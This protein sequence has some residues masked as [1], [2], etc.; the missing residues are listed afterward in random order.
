MRI[1]ISSGHGLKVRGASCPSPGLDEVNEA[2]KTVEKIAEYM[3]AGGHTA[4][5]FHDDTSTSVNQNLSTIVNFH[6]RQTRDWDISCHFNAFQRT[7]SPMGTETLYVSSTGQTMASKVSPALAKAG[8]FI[9]RG[10][11]KR[12][13][14]YFLNK[15]NKPSILLEICFVDSYADADLYRANFNA[16]CQAV[17]TA[18]TGTTVPVEPPVEPEVPPTQPPPVDTEDNQIDIVGEVKGDV[19]VVVNDERLVG[20]EDCPNVVTLK[21][22]KT[23]DV[24]LT[25][26]GQEFH[27]WPEDEV[28]P[29]GGGGGP[30][31]VPLENRPTISRGD[32]GKDVTDMQTLIP[33]F[34]GAIDGDFGP[35][36]QTNVVNYQA[37][38]GLAADGI[39]GPKTWSALY[40]ATP[41]LAAPPYAL[42]TT[43]QQ[44]ICMIANSSSI[45]SY[46]WKNRG[47]AP[48]GY[49]MGMALAFAQTYK[50]L[51]L[52]ADSATKMARAMTTSDKDALYVYRNEYAALGMSNA[53]A[54]ID[55]L[56]H[57]FAL[58]LGSGMRESSGKHCAGRDQ[59]A[60][61][62]TSETAEAGLF[63]TSYNARSANNPTFDNLMTEY[64]NTN[65]KMTCY[66][67]TFDDGV[68]CSTSDW[69]CY[70]SGAGY[71]FQKLSKECPSFAVETHGLT[72]R[73]LCNHYGPIIRKEAELRGEANTMFMAVQDYLDQAPVA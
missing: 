65:N 10:A 55:T 22:T 46:G 15:T 11:K 31:D 71:Q 39:C 44:A 49:T 58:M 28:P 27:N 47:R 14:L 57:L 51:K 6:N 21:V 50:K 73:N 35:T 4:T 24:S 3:R 62:T 38:R 16:I 1:V 8:K 61:N 26:N 7:N 54:G 66:L 13:D 68:T 72:L 17:A 33:G 69:S 5:T 42:S 45:A 67:G 18:V 43:E 59:S 30:T 9:N 64:S 41:P 32:K 70:G 29:T 23:G 53:T 48:V 40:A 60:S 52:G 36:T 20:A 37:S 19:T 2:R 12:T 25:I 56:R 63:Q 34:T